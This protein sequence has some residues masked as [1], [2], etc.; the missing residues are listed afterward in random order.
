MKN[1]LSPPADTPILTTW[2][3]WQQQANDVLWGR[4]AGGALTVQLWRKVR[5][6]QL[7]P[8]HDRVLM[9]S[10]HYDNSAPVNERKY[11]VFTESKS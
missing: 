8:V 9:T 6:M 1:F 7:F 4:G 3:P 2:A 10:A 5:E 11:M